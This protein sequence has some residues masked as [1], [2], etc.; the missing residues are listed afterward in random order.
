MPFGEIRDPG[1]R[2]NS[3]GAQALPKQGELFPGNA[4]L[5]HGGSPLNAPANRPTKDHSSTALVTPAGAGLV[6]SPPSRQA[7]A[8]GFERQLEIRWSNRSSVE[9][10]NAWNELLD[11]QRKY[12]SA[13]LDIRG[14]QKRLL[15]AEKDWRHKLFRSLRADMYQVP[16][17]INTD[18]ISAEAVGTAART[19]SHCKGHRRI[20][21][22]DQ[23]RC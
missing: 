15:Q 16:Q 22:P 2:F 18:W 20:G 11:M 5:V 17:Q 1:R 4:G 10:S 21:Q 8:G 23:H 19:R 7:A 12:N 6:T 13:V 14:A 9:L 3:A